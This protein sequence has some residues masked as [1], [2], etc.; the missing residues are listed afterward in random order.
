MVTLDSLAVTVLAED[1][2]GYETPY[3]GQHGI[4]LYLTA[5]RDG[6]ITN[7]LFDVAQHPEPLLANMEMLG[8]D[9][10]S[11][12]AVVLSHCHYDHTQGLASVVKAIG[13]NDLPVIGHRDLFRPHFISNPSLRCIGVPAKDGPDEI[14]EAGGVFFPV[15]GSFEISPGLVTS[16]EV[17]RKTE[18]EGVGMALKT[19]VDGEVVTDEVL[20][21]LSLYASVGDKGLVVL[22]GCSHAGI[23]NITRQGRDHTGLNVV[24]AVIGGFHLIEASDEKI[25]KTAEGLAEL[26][27]QRLHAGHCTGFKAQMELARVFGERFAPMRTGDR[28]EI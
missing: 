26:E 1:T 2:V 24:E 5:M 16:G 12:D 9:P 21:D 7:V 6:R 11:V 15:T 17:V 28:Y 20:D 8:I 3:L 23:V 13:K 10:S 14:R 4:S 25:R 18:Y 22:T 19:L 27:I